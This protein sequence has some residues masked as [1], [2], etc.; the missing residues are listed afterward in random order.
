MCLRNGGNE[1]EQEFTFVF[2]VEEV[3]MSGYFHSHPD[4]VG[5]VTVSS[6][7]SSG[8]PV[9]YSNILITSTIKADTY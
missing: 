3:A 7:A 9:K 5:S 4:E 6:P 2:T 1:V 8:K